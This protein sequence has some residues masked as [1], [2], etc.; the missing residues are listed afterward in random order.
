MKKLLFT[1]I[2]A[3]ATS[4]AIIAQS[5]IDALQISQTDF[6]GTARY[7]GMGGAFTA[8]GGDLSAVTQNPAGIGIYRRNEI[9]AT[10]DLSF[11]TS[12]SSG[13]N[14]NKTNF[15]CNNFGYVGVANLDGVMETFAWGASYN[16]RAQFD[17]VTTGRANSTATSL[18]NYIASF[19]GNYSQD[20]LDF[21][22][23]YNPYES[24]SVPWLSAL[25][26]A[27]YLINPQT[28]TNGYVG[29]YQ[30]GTVGDAWLDVYESGYMDEYNFTFGGNFSNTVYWGVGVGVTDLQYKRYTTYSESMSGAL[31]YSKPANGLATCDAG[32]TL[33]NNK[34]IAGTGWKIDFGLIFK[35]T[36]EFRIGAAIHTPQYW[37]LDENYQGDL[38]YSN[39]DKSYSEISG[40]N[41]TQG[42]EYTDWADF[43]WRLKS[44]WRFSVG[45]AGVLGNN[46]IISVDYERVA[47]N[48]MTVKNSS[49][50]SGFGGDYYEY[51]QDNATVNNQIRTYT[52]GGNIVRA[53]LE[54]RVTPQFS[55]RA[56]YNIELSNITDAAANNQVEVVTDPLSTDPSYS[57]N[58]TTQHVSLGLGYRFGNWYLDGTY[59]YG[60]RESTMHPYSS[61]AGGNAPVYDVT[62]KTHSAVVSL[63]FKF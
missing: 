40:T 28:G 51:Y 36:N 43:S 34:R 53:G 3:A 7:M 37:S 17:R 59:V 29:M 60:N 48:D 20:M 25:G 35:P 2:V 13:F 11:V 42:S 41:P 23:N 15:S 57:L 21:G 52:R 6:R 62:D 9:G 18:S 50:N 44:P 22:E 45:V 54:Y 8:L 31:A 38:T 63:G 26:Y 19:S 5:A 58:K 49:Y 61:F 10:A 46:A 24:G 32:F 55:V 4:P 27:T 56:G 47:Y 1:A 12:S 39:L 14:N 16:R 33:N 30:N